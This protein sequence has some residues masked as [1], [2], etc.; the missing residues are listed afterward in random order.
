MLCFSFPAITNPSVILFWN[1]NLP[2]NRSPYLKLN[3]GD[4]FID[5]LKV[6]LKLTF[7]SLG[8]VKGSGKFIEIPS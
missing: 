1:L 4:S 2:L 8:F 7:E 5:D 6:S 3:R